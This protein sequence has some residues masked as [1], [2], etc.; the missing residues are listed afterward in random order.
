MTILE[1]LIK[2]N[3]Y[4]VERCLKKDYTKFEIALFAGVVGLIIGIINAL[5]IYINTK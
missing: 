1:T 3:K 2:K 4:F 5:I